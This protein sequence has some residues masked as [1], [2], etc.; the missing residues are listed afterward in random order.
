MA[1]VGRADE[2]IADIRRLEQSSPLAREQC[3]VALVDT[4]LAAERPG[5]ALAEAKR[6][7]QSGIQSVTLKSLKGI[8]LFRLE[9][10][11]EARKIFESVLEEV[12][13]HQVAAVFLRLIDERLGHGD[14]SLVA[15]LIEP[16]PLPNGLRPADDPPENLRDDDIAWV[17]LDA[18]TIEFQ[19]D[20]DYKLTRTRVVHVLNRDG[21]EA[22]SRLQFP[23][24]SL[25]EQLFLNHA[26]VFD[27]QGRSVGIVDQKDCFV[28][29]AEDNGLATSQ[30][31][32]HV[33]LPGLRPGYRIEYQVTWQEHVSSKAFPSQRFSTETWL[34][35]AR[36]VISISGDVSGVGWTGPNPVRSP[37]RLLWDMATTRHPNEPQ[38]DDIVIPDSTICLGS[39]QASWASVGKDYLDELKDRLVPSDE[40]RRIA[41]KLLVGLENAPA[42]A[43]VD[44]LTAWVRDELTYQGIE[45]GWRAW[46]MP[47][48]EQTI[49]NRYGDC[50]DH[51]LLLW[52]L[53]N[54]AGIK[55][56][57]AMVSV[58][59]PV[60]MRLP[61][62][63]QFDH[64]IVYVE[65]ELG[66]RFIDATD[67]LV[68]SSVR[69]PSGLALKVAL[70]LASDAPRLIRLPDYPRDYS[71]AWIDRSIELTSRGD[72]EVKET[73][74]LSGH[75]ASLMRTVLSTYDRDGRR[76]MVQQL[77]PDGDDCEI[78]S[79]EIRNLHEPASRLIVTADYRLLQ[80]MYQLPDQLV[81]R[82]TLLS[83]I[84]SIAPVEKLD[85]TT[86]FRLHYPVNTTAVVRIR[87][88]E[89]T[90]I[91]TQPESLQTR[92]LQLERNVSSNDDEV[93]IRVQLRR[94][95]GRFVSGAWEAWQANS[96]QVID[97]LSPNLIVRRRL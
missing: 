8:A 39:R 65:D 45:F 44:R 47:P 28:L 13:N 80:L 90:E 84:T 62:S 87:G 7:E 17:A 93:E 37:D 40:A 38:T 4:L 54:A 3:S 26:E 11:N 6:L 32:L 35:T 82:L 78:T 5:N 9:R 70:V 76:S 20:D 89:G 43:R 25:A 59:E 53:L 77:L 94:N 69:V 46:I 12:P 2:A 86:S 34:P 18:R 50:K 29:A 92:T 64:M 55:C 1:K 71:R 79:F 72:A 22:F 48:V 14:S 52:Q 30:Q 10:H 66:A 51:S 31:I 97:S 24:D 33:P 21:V 67:K 81:G 19:P 23:F 63:R 42:S 74:E 49:R 58:E 88:P 61:S 41:S 56:H 27:T 57:L 16:V 83:R 96:R 15:A 91:V 60:E 68:D 95:C 73:I 85:R 75:V 36:F